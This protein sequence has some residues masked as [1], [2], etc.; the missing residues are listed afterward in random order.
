MSADP[1]KASPSP[2]P[3][4][5]PQLPQLVDPPPIGVLVGLLARCKEPG[6]LVRALRAS[7][8][9][10]PHARWAPELAR[11]DLRPARGADEAG[12]PVLLVRGRLP[13]LA[14]VAVVGARAADPY[15]EAVARRVAR[16]AVE[17]GLPVVS[18][19]AEG[20]DAAAHE[21]ALEA[22]GPT[23]VVLGAGHD[24]P[25]PARHRDLF[26]AVVGAGGAV[27]SAF[28]PDVRPAKH[29]FLLRNRVIAW[30]SAVTVV[31]RAGG[32]SGALSTA[33]AARALGRPVLAVPGNVGEALSAGGNG[34]LA[35]G[36]R[37]LV[38]PR[39]LAR[40]L[41][42]ADEAGSLTEGWSVRH[43]GDPSP[44]PWEETPEDVGEERWGGAPEPAALAAE[45][46]LVLETLRSRG[47]LDLD[48][49]LMQTGLGID[50]L[51][52]TLMDLDVGR[53]VERLPGERW[54]A[55]SG[56]PSAVTARR[57]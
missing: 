9:P 3:P 35:D 13:D 42:L 57:Q 48:G 20:C 2:S 7:E 47:S 14:G 39:D 38:G 26:E 31:A 21:A 32:R 24:H 23:V 12:A 37:A 52:A 55:L 45:A 4:A 34:L 50:L 30:L 28:W 19:G 41:G 5:Q 53:Q 16:D 6:R 44:W 43:L 51:V 18:G 17:L 49:L 15:G 40:A 1:P 46:Q 11:R 54:R 56:Q 22:G 27:V 36:A 8:R 10:E 29:R 25:Y 33:A